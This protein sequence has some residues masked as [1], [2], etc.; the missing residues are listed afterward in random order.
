MDTQGQKNADWGYQPPAPGWY[1]MTFMDGI[2]EIKKE[3]GDKVKLSLKI[4]LQANE[5]YGGEAAE[6]KMSVFIPLSGETDKEIGFAKKK[7]ADVLVNAGLWEMFEKKYPGDISI[8]DKRI[9]DGAKIKLPE[10]Q[11]LVKIEE[12]VSKKDN[13]TYTNIV[14]LAPRDFKPEL[15]EK[16]EKSKAA[17]KG[18]GKGKTETAAAGKDDDWE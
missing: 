5:A 18:S 7:M 10:K 16:K 3:D 1:Y 11:I 15:E 13:K 12:T 9:I 17:D 14:R 4:P 2:E 8:L 6:F